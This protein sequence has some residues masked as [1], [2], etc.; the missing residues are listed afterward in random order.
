LV[1]GKS[2]QINLKYFE[3]FKG[4]SQLILAFLRLL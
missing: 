2:T 3:Y 4:M 1:S